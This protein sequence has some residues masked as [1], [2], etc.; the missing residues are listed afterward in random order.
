MFYNFICY[1]SCFCDKILDKSRLKTEGFIYIRFKNTV[2]HDKEA[3]VA[4]ADLA[5]SAPYICSQEA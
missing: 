2:H 3:M 5:G 1:L 4:G